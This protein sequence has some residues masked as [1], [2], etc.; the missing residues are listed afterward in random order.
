MGGSSCG[1]GVVCFLLYHVFPGNQIASIGQSMVKHLVTA[2]PIVLLKLK[3]RFICTPLIGRITASGLQSQ[4]P[5]VRRMKFA[6][7][8]GRIDP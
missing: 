4:Q 8:D 6:K 7:G 2:L 5:L 3:G 1:P